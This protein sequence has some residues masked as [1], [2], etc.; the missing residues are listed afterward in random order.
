MSEKEYDMSVRS[1]TTTER[2]KE[3]GQ[4]IKYKLVARDSEGVNEVVINSA[5]PFHGLVPQAKIQ[6]VLRNPQK[7]LK[8]AVKTPDKK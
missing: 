3:D 1:L 7:T 6:I 8:D 5:S 2:K 4:T